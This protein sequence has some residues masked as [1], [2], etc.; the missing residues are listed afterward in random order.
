MSSSSVNASAFKALT[1]AATDAIVASDDSERIL[2]ANP[3]ALRAFGYEADELANLQLSAL[4]PPRFREMHHAGMQR[5]VSTGIANVIGRTVELAGLRKNGEEFPLELSLGAW[6]AD[7]GKQWFIG[8]MRDI[9]QRKAAEAA[10]HKEF[11]FVQLLESIAAAANEAGNFAEAV[12]VCLDLVCAELKWPLGHAYQVFRSPDG[13]YLQPMGTWSS[14]GHNGAF[15]A[16]KQHT[17]KQRFEPGIGLPGRVFSSGTPSCLPAID[18]DD[19]FPRGE[20]ARLSGLKSGFA[21]PVLSR[22]EVVAVLEFFSPISALPEP[23]TMEVMTYAAAQLGR[24]IERELSE[25]KIRMIADGISEAVY[26][27]DSERRLTYVNPAFERLTGYSRAALFQTN[28]IPY[29]AAEQMDDVHRLWDDLFRGKS[30]E[31]EF[32]ITTKS[33]EQKWIESSWTPQFDSSGKQTGVIGV[34]RDVTRRRMAEGALRHANEE[35]AKDAIMLG[36]QQSDMETL[37]KLADQLQAC[38]TMAEAYGVIGAYCRNL[39]P[40]H[41]GAL[42]VT[43]LEDGALR[44]EAQWGEAD[45]QTDFQANQC[46]A[47]RTGRTYQFTKADPAL[48]CDHITDPPLN[49]Y[50]C[51]PIMARGTVLG[52]LHLR[53]SRPTGISRSPGFEN[54]AEAVTRQTALAFASLRLREQL[55]VQVDEDAL[56]GLFNRRYM[57]SALSSEIRRATLEKGVV[58]LLVLDVDHFKS[59]NDTYGHIRGDDILRAIADYLMKNIRSGDL[60]CRYGGEE[61]VMILPNSAVANA[62]TKAESLRK[63]IEKLQPLPDA[64]KSGVTISVGVAAFPENGSTPEQVF[65]SADAALYQAKTQGRNRVVA[66]V[67]AQT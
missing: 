51:N 23:R 34:E 32:L 45:M 48:R 29:I 55:E 57:D 53:S 2:Y 39:F 11:A 52:L 7:D 47:L 46:W 37:S 15:E 24:V 8:I 40:D 65:R 54:L 30:F 56:T 4:M 38:Q 61:F 62:I 63:G 67:A 42:Y 22:T 14:P 16:F 13:V 26:S 27:Y 10:L 25:Q 58:S 60:V 3:A 12:Q 33:G 59:Y 21:V 5:Y 35:L 43:S 64:T 41:A 44:R 17:M 50:M 6:P 18:D 28:F 1:E 31:Q 49:P 66:A 9:T 36:Q 19:N 20:S